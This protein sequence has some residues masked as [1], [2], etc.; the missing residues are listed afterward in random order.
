MQGNTFESNLLTVK[1]F[2]QKE[3]TGKKNLFS[4]QPSSWGESSAEVGSLKIDEL[5]LCH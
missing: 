2:I 4:S 1:D 5:V 3:S